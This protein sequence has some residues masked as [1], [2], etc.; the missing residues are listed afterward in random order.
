MRK[1]DIYLWSTLAFAIISHVIA[2]LQFSIS[3]K[4]LDVPD[5]WYGQFAILMGISLMFVFLQFFLYRN[6]IAV[7]ISLFFRAFLL[8]IATYPQGSSMNV[9]TTL[10]ASLV[11]DA[12]IYPP[13]LIGF[14]VCTAL[15]TLSV[16]NRWAGPSWDQWG[17]AAPNDSVFFTGFYPLMIMALA[18]FLK[19]AQKLS[20]ERKRL[21]EQLQHASTSLVETNILLQKHIVES[22]EKAKAAERERIS[23]E[24]H[25]TIGYTLMNILATL[26]ASMELSRTDLGAMREF[27]SRSMEQAQKGLVDTRTALRAIRAAT[28]EPQPLVSMVNRLVSAFKGTHIKVSA[29]Y[30]NVPWFFGGEVDSTI[31]HVVQEG[32]TNAIRHGDATAI[33]V[34]LSFDGE[35]I[36]VTISDNG[37]GSEAIKE[38]FGLQGI[39]GRLS[40]VGGGLTVKNVAGGVQLYAWIPVKKG[41]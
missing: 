35:R 36:G 31:F 24:L 25:D 11:F 26:K 5:R 22:E 20:V 15:I 19:N 8:I 2:F 30:S 17:F 28:I 13:L 41:A 27:M 21:V 6:G 39:R 32:I 18:G 16:L 9:R 3:V 4:S 37:N 1:R 40:L 12:M 14:I 38:G 33:S 34:H 7:Y 29:I 10:L 23:R